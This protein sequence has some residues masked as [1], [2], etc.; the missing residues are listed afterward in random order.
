[1]VS[2]SE[3]SL[4]YGLT[5]TRWHRFSPRYVKCVSSDQ[6]PVLIYHAEIVLRAWNDLEIFGNL[7]LPTLDLIDSNGGMHKN[8]IY[9]LLH[10]AIYCQG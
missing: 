10:E 9:A 5:Y 3:I 2:I 6:T 1:M 4:E 8:I 7:T